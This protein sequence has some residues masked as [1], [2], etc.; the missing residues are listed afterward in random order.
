MGSNKL[1][2]DLNGKVLLRHSVEALK[3]SSV[4]DIVVVTGNEPELVKKAIEPLSVRFAHN[5]NYADGLST[6]LKRGLSA[7]SAEMDGV[8]VCLGDERRCLAAAA[9]ATLLLAD[10]WFDVCTSPPG[11][12][13]LLA[14]GEAVLVELPLAAAAIWL[15]VAL[16]RDTGRARLEHARY[17]DRGRTRLVPALP[18]AVGLCGRDAAEPGAREPARCPGP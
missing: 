17:G 12:D 14:V 18:P 13:R 9:S 15:A 2:A 5:S 1:L 16:T 10:A 6:S 7:I 8:L 4:Q 3:T 11:L